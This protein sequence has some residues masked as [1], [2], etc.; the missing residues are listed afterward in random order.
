[1]LSTV[2]GAAMSLR[3][4]LQDDAWEVGGQGQAS[5]ILFG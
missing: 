4:Q 3:S 5:A 2:S 1:M